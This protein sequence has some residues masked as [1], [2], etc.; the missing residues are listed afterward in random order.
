MIAKYSVAESDI[1]NFNKT[2]FAMSII[3]IKMVV[4]SSERR[5][6]PRLR[7]QGNKEWVTVIQGI[8]S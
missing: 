7:Q 4:I 8:N 2:G 6:R 1:Y 3:L 5:G